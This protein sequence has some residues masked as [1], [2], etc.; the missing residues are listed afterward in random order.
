MGQV[1]DVVAVRPTSP[2]HGAAPAGRRGHA[3]P[4]AVTAVTVLAAALG[5]ARVAKDGLWR[6]EAFTAFITTRSLGH[7]WSIIVDRELNMGL[8]Y[9]LLWGWAHIS[10]ADAWLRAP[11]VVMAAATVPVMAAVARRLL[12]ARTA[13]LT[14]LLLALSP[15][16]TFYAGFA[17]T[18]SLTTFLAVASTWSLLRA[19]D[20]PGVRWRAGYV[21]VSVLLVVSSPLAVLMVAAHAVAL[22]TVR[23]QR[24]GWLPL[25][26]T[27]G[28]IALLVSPVLLR[29]VLAQTGMTGW[30]PPLSLTGLVHLA[31]DLAGAWWLVPVYALAG[32]AWSV[33]VLRRA[34]S[35]LGH[36]LTAPL[37]TSWLVVPL[38]A[39]TAISAVKPLLIGRYVA[40]V[41]P[42]LVL[43]LAWAIT[44]VPGRAC[45][46]VVAAVLVVDGA[47]LVDEVFLRPSPEPIRAVAE[48]IAA[49]SQPGDVVLFAPAHVRVA[50]GWY[51]AAERAAGEVVP[52][53][54]AVA[55][56]AD[57]VGDEFPVEYG[58]DQLAGI[59]AGAPRIW[60]VSLPGDEWHPTP[61]P[62]LEVAGAVRQD[63]RLA[64]ERRFDTLVVELYTPQG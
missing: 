40:F 33:A 17:R 4:L 57:S 23:R 7:T 53:D 21:A 59:V 28:A 11:S 36:A 15:I 63:R 54:V 58:A 22:A 47:T 41:V 42:V 61:E 56:S 10:S 34:P 62:G 9:L 3:Y 30:I 51:L 20:R 64:Y 49:R 52:D 25:V 31:E 8:Y 2:R 50:V 29:L 60:V 26:W 24:G 39:L 55:R 13:V 48:D 27:Y 45:A 16:F 19:W 12:G 46:V 6:D 1:H 5:A 35:T 32:A 38:V 18:Y 44:R 37:V 43:V 14:V